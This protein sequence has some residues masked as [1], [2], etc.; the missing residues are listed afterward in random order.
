MASYARLP[1]MVILSGAKDLT[2]EVCDT[3][4]KERDLLAC[5]RFCCGIEMTIL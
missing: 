5:V 4:G 2:H 3:L 1:L